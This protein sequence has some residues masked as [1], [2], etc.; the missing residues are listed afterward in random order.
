VLRLLGGLSLT[1]ATIL[2]GLCAGRHER[3]RIFGILGVASGVA[4]LTGGL[5]AG[6]AVGRWGFGTILTGLALVCL[7]VPLA[8]LL[9]QEAPQ[10]ARPERAAQARPVPLGQAPWLLIGATL[11][12]L[13]AGRVAFHGRL[14]RMPELGLSASSISLALM[15]VNVA[16]IVIPFPAGWLSDR[17]G[18]K[19][20]VLGSYALGA[21]G[22]VWMALARTS[23][24]F[25]LASVLLAAMI[26]IANSLG[27]AWITDL[28]PREG[29][30]QGLS[31][32][33]AGGWVADALGAAGAGVA[34]QQLGMPATFG[35]G[36]ALVVLAA[37]LASRI[38]VAK[39]EA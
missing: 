23:W 26:S 21:L 35:L 28:A 18:R 25:A 16:S 6:A 24:G 11:A 12:A 17:W 19:P 37:L 32:F 33:I 10:A 36:V 31:L 20:L 13:T 5:G 9:L 4:A 14:L 2:A 27:R 38:R 29:L 1:S 7:L 39:S 15:A 3:G 34:F 22:L 8:G 30:S